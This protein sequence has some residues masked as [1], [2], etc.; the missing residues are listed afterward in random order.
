MTEQFVTVWL[1]RGV[2][3]TVAAKSGY[4]TKGLRRRRQD[5]GVTK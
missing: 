5:G 3:Y 2:A 1:D 4:A